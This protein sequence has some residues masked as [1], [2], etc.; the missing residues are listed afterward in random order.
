MNTDTP[1]PRTD[2]AV[3]N[4]NFGNEL[5]QAEVARQ[6]ERELEE[7]RRAEDAVIACHRATLTERDQLRAECQKLRNIIDTTEQRLGG[8]REDEG[9]WDMLR[10]I[11]HEA[12]QLRSDNAK[13]R[14]ALFNLER[15]AG[16]AA[17]Y[18]D[19]V[20]VA[21]RAALKGGQP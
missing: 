14:E 10:R 12:D 13:L 1:T 16:Q 9:Y 21:A 19:P 8:L 20:R 18:D 2:A 17:M 15:M 4:K 7:A 11:S 3:I 5:M 6:L